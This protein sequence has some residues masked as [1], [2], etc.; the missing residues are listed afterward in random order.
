M[1]YMEKDGDSIVLK[2]PLVTADQAKEVPG[3]KHESRNRLWR[4][5]LSWATCVVARGVF[6][7]DLEVGPELA[8]WAQKER[9]DRVIP[10]TQLRSVSDQELP[11]DGQVAPPSVPDSEVSW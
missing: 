6:G 1:I 2:A 10:A 8:S 7:D 5:P 9:D 11:V 4:Y 3:G